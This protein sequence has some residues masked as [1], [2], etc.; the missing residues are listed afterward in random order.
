MILRVPIKKETAK[1]IFAEERNSSGGF[2]CVLAF[3]PVHWSWLWL[4][5]NDVK[6]YQQTTMFVEVSNWDFDSQSV[7]LKAQE[8][9]VDKLVD[10]VCTREHFELPTVSYTFVGAENRCQSL[11]LWQKRSTQRGTK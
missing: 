11:L 1:E 6:F 7:F 8:R 4:V 10:L 9:I 3:T 5:G 2:R